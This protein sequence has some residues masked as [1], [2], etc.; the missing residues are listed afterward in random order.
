MERGRDKVKPLLF[1]PCSSCRPN[2]SSDLDA[3]VRHRLDLPAL[4]RHSR[5]RSVAG[6]PSHESAVRCLM[7][8]MAHRNLVQA[9][10]D[11]SC[12][13]GLYGGPLGLETATTYEMLHH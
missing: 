2:C 7:A 3:K 5:G 4:G 10:S 6:F 1:R 12:R 13:S 8:A 11:L 9:T